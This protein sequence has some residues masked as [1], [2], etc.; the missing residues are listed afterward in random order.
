MKKGYREVKA[1][2]AVILEP[3]MKNGGNYNRRKHEIS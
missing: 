1:A 2:G 3:I